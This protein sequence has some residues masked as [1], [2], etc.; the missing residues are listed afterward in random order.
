M[1]IFDYLIEWPAKQGG[2]IVGGLMHAAYT[3]SV[4]AAVLYSAAFV[5]QRVRVPI[6]NIVA[7]GAVSIWLVCVLVEAERFIALGML[8]AVEYTRDI[9]E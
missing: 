2:Y 8:Q 9:V 3:V 4:F 1:W 7:A 6:V 5:Y